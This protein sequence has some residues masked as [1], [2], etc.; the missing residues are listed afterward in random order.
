MVA[1]AR[2]G[3]RFPRTGGRAPGCRLRSPALPAG[4]QPLAVLAARSHADRT[5]G[6]KKWVPITD[7]GR[8]V[9]EAISSTSRVEVLVA[10][11]A[12]GLAI[13]SSLANTSFLT[14]I[15][16]RR[17]RD[18][19]RPEGLALPHH[20]PAVRRPH[21]PPHDPHRR[22]PHDPSPRRGRRHQDKDR[23]PHL[24]A[25]GITEY[26][27]NGGKLE[28]A[29]QMANHESARTTGLYDRRN[30]QVSLDEVELILI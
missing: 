24:P 5:D 28:V 16:H 17:R 29:Q 26:L 13:R 1:T 18:R 3:R 10:S 23:L 19:C 30:D 15:L 22:L 27:R 2:Q 7:S 20:R 4:A 6:L 12:S 14:C 9:A 8:P 11:T 21:R 25:T